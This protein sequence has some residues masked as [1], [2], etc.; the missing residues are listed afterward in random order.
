MLHACFTPFASCFV[1]TSWHFYAISR[2]NLL[3]RCHSASS[4]FSAVFV[5]QKSYTGNILGIGR[6]EDRNSYFAGRKD[7][8]QTRAGGGPEGTLTTRGHSP[9]PGRTH[10]WW[11][12]LVPPLT[13]PFRLYNA[14]GWKT[15]KQS[16]FFPEQFRSAAAVED[17]FRGDRSLYSGTLPG[18]GSA[19]GAISIDVV[20]SSAVSIYFTSISTNLAVSYDEEGVVLPQGWGLYR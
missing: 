2:T 18:R 15:L 1:Y 10:L 3:A 6:N 13:P 9:G 17:K 5:F 20:A 14:S 16:A 7:E 11:G 4:L 12:R 19:P 8:D